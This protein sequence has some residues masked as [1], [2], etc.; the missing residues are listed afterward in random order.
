MR[1]IFKSVREK[2]TS[3]YLENSSLENNKKF[4]PRIKARIRRN[5]Q[6][7]SKNIEKKITSLIN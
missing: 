4:K 2:L 3:R 6:I 7:I 5:K 1:E